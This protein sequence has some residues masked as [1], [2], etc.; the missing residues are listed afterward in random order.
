[1]RYIGIFTSLILIL[2]SLNN[3][4]P[5][6]GDKTFEYSSSISYGDYEIKMIYG[7]DEGSI[8]IDIDSTSPVNI[9]ITKEESLSEVKE[10]AEQRSSI[11]PKLKYYQKVSDDTLKFK[12]PDSGNF[13][14]YFEHGEETSQSI[15]MNLSFKVIEPEE[16][17]KIDMIFIIIILI[18]FF[19]IIPIA[20]WI[21]KKV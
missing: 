20:Y 6:G 10:Y 9:Y 8:N 1:M 17:F 16:G 11:F 15:D 4:V 13:I 2:V 14:F 19:V 5:V 3:I 7:P 21:R 12:C 18:P